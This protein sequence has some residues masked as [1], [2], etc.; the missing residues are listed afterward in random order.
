M[1]YISPENSAGVAQSVV[2]DEQRVYLVPFRWWKEA[3]NASTSDSSG[4][5]GV[6]YSASPSSSYAGAMKLIN[7]I[8]S[9]DLL[10]NLRREEESSNDNGEVGVSGRDY[11][12]VSGEMW[13]QALK[14]HSDSKNAMKR[15][16]SFSAGDV[17]IADVYPLQLRLS[18]LREANSLGV[19]ISKRDNAAELFRRA[20]KIFNI[21]AELL[22][23]RDFSGRTSHYLMS[24][25]GSPP[26]DI[27]RQSDQEVK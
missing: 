16:G 21:E 6:L 24:D 4:K 27:Q 15:V 13:L 9:S 12:L 17:D 25:N 23:I 18:V 11:A 7:N 19:K 14:W 8:F 2:N 20:C 3:Q 22:H 5:R 1:E 10:F 26:K